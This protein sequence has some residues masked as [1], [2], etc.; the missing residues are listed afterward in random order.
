[1]DQARVSEWFDLCE[2]KQ[3]FETSHFSD[4]FHDFFQQ[5]FDDAVKND[6]QTIFGYFPEPSRILQM[7]SQLRVRAPDLTD[8][9]IVDLVKRDLAE[10][11]KILAMD[12]DKYDGLDQV[13]N[14]IDNGPFTLTVDKPKFNTARESGIQQPF[15]LCLAG[16]VQR[17]L[18]ECDEKTR[19]MNQAFYGVAFNAEL[20]RTLTSQLMD[21][22]VNFDHYFSLYKIGV[23]YAFDSNEVVIMNHRAAYAK[24]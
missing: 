20:Q 12:A 15:A 16:Y 8:D 4:L 10:K 5:P 7:F 6:L 9:Q 19:A 22:D 3:E 21:L 14:I 11:R 23:D 2:G 1:V 17:L 13:I 24:R 18:M